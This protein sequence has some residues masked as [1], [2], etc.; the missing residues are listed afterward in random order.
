[1]DENQN[2]CIA[3][4]SSFLTSFRI[5]TLVYAPLCETFA[6]KPNELLRD[7][8]NPS[9]VGLPSQ[10]LIP[11][12]E[13]PY[14]LKHPF[15]NC[16]NCMRCIIRI[17]RLDEAKVSWNAV[18]INRETDQRIPPSPQYDIAPKLLSG[19]VPIYPV[20]RLQRSSCGRCAPAH[21]GNSARHHSPIRTRKLGRRRVYLCPSGLGKRA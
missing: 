4:P 10:R 7:R 19:R 3:H 6:E 8:S 9:R 18:L 15:A 2:L 21:C 5:C 14:G 1:M 11:T 13:Q 17:I 12:G 20:T 16:D